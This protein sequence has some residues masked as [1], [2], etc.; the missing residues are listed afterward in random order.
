VA[1]AG[2]IARETGG[3]IPVSTDPRIQCAQGLSFGLHG[4]LQADGLE[5]YGT[6]LRALGAEGR[7]G[8][9]HV[10]CMAHARRMFVKADRSGKVATSAGTALGYIRKLYAVER[11]ATNANLDGAERAALRRLKAFPILIGFRKWM[12]QRRPEVPPES[13]IGKA[14]G[15]TLGQWERLVR[16]IDYGLVPI[17][18]NQVL[19]KTKDKRPRIPCVRS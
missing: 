15:Y 11:K 9:V 6:A 10:G 2:R 4:V 14:I 8:I 3:T 12:D 7:S 18:N 16:Y 1:C 17:D 13:L 19:S 5:A